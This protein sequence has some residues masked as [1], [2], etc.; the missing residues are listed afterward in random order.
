VAATIHDF[1]IA[2]SY[3]CCFKPCLVAHVPPFSFDHEHF[4]H[5]PPQPPPHYPHPHRPIND[6]FH[7]RHNETRV[8]CTI[9]ANV[10][11]IR[12]LQSHWLWIILESPQ[13]LRYRRQL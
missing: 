13:M 8:V 11:R 3:I 5:Y 9:E 7:V 10:A 1:S 6:L 12:P 2:I 4:H